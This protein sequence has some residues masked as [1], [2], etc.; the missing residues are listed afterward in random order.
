MSSINHYDFVITIKIVKFKANLIR[1]FSST[2]TFVFGIIQ[3][4]NT[5][6]WFHVAFIRF[7]LKLGK[8]MM[9][10]KLLDI[11]MDKYDI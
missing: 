9:V 11:L 3:S 8:I 4:I 7:T 1:T 6:D 2:F 5:H 10:R